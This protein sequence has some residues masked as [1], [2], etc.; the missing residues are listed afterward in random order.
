MTDEY[1]L[2]RRPKYDLEQLF[3]I[4]LFYLLD[5]Q[6]ITALKPLRLA[7]AQHHEEAAFLVK[8]LEVL[9]THNINDHNNDAVAEYYQTS[10]MNSIDPRAFKYRVWFAITRQFS[11][12]SSILDNLTVESLAEPIIQYS[13]AYYEYRNNHVD[14]TTAVLWHR[15]AAA[16]G[17]APSMYELATILDRRKNRSPSVDEEIAAMFVRSAELGYKRAIYRITIQRHLLLLKHRLL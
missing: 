1:W 14:D 8:H 4:G 2:S 13:I 15:Q 17:F 10:F 11:W 7:A 16:Q 6:G 3:R 9:A 12:D 5:G